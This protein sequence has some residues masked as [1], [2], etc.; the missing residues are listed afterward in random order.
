VLL[1]PRP[2]VETALRLSRL[3]TVMAIVHDAAEAERL[4]AG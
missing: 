1:N 3:D 2:D 4:A